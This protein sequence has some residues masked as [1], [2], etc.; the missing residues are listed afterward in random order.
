MNQISIESAVN[1]MQ[2]TIAFI[3]G[4]VGLHLLRIALEAHVHVAPRALY[5]I[6][7][8]PPDNWHSTPEIDTESHSVLLYV[9]FEHQIIL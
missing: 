9:L 1:S 3:F 4:G 6:A 7:A 5:M 8:S 2:M